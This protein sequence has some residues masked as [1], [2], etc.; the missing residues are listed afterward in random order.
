MLTTN[1]VYI[2]EFNKGL[3]YWHK[4]EDGYILECI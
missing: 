4:M 1:A 2:V 3:K